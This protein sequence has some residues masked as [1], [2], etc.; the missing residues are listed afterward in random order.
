MVSAAFLWRVFPMGAVLFQRF[1]GTTSTPPL[2]V[3]VVHC[4][5]S[6]GVAALVSCVVL[7]ARC[8]DVLI[9]IPLWIWGHT[10][11]FLGGGGLFPFLEEIC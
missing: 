6:G 9:L 8:I 7:L 10:G 3:C 5:C 4:A 1:D 2:L 11:L